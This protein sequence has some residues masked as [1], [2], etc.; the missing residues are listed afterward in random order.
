[1]SGRIP[2]LDG[3]RAVSIMMV[4]N[5]HV[6]GTA[7]FPLT[8]MPFA[9]G[10]LG[11][12]VFFVISGY[13]ITT[14]LLAEQAKTGTISLRK[15]YLR[16]TI[17]IF[18]AFYVYLAAVLILQ[19]NGFLELHRGDLL[20]A[21]TYTMNF[22]A[23]RSWWLGHTWSLSVEEQ[24]YLLWPAVVMLF[25]A[26]GGLRAALGAI[27]AAPLLRVAV[28]YGWPSQRA[29]VDQAF[30]MIFD[31]LATGCAL[32]MARDRLWQDPRYR[33]LLDSP[34][35]ALVPLIVVA[36]YLYI[37]S[38]GVQLLAGQT[39]MHVGIALC[40]DWAIRFPHTRIGRVLNARPLAWLGTI[41]YS[42]YLWQQ[43]FL[44]RHHLSWITAF[45]QNLGLA[46]A[47]AIL[48]YQLIEQP[49]LRLRARFGF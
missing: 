5:G 41:S 20:A 35:F 13:L 14:L 16:R 46:F 8:W 38:V 18:P 11:V 27:L 40:I 29:L 25:G 33:R 31:G 43:L 17:R 21:A 44:C 12:T 47:S 3:L 10:G 42:L 26:A 24:F 28:F 1:M 39:I 48:S 9:W 23:E 37:P 2:S 30:P 15:F 32:A 34:L 22:R 19:L 36:A 45:P 4:L 7:G 49:L 6:L